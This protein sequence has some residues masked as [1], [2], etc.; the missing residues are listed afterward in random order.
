MQRV[1]AVMPTEVAPTVAAISLDMVT[2]VAIA[3][4]AATTVLEAAA[5]S[6]TK[7]QSFFSYLF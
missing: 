2:L 6:A 7:T 4:G 3:A 1:V 5:C